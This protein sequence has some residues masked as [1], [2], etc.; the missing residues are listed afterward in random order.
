[1]KVCLSA[2]KECFVFCWLFPL[3][4]SVV[5]LK[6]EFTQK[7]II[8]SNIFLSNKNADRKIT[9]EKLY[10]LAENIEV[11]WTTSTRKI[12]SPSNSIFNNRDFDMWHI[13]SENF[14]NQ[15]PKTSIEVRNIFG[16]YS[17]SAVCLPDFYSDFSTISKFNFVLISFN[18]LLIIS[19]TVGYL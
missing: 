5:V 17:S 8:S 14:R 1:M 19:I 13:N 16:F 7:M 18:L 10:N 4:M 15:F 3:V 12:I 11:V 6:P 9:P 2:K